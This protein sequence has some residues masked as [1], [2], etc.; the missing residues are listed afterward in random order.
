MENLTT[1]DRGQSKAFSVNGGEHRIVD[2][3]VKHRLINT[4]DSNIQYTQS[5]EYVNKDR[6]L[7]IQSGKHTRYL[8]VSDLSTLRSRMCSKG[9]L[10]VPQFSMFSGGGIKADGTP[11]H[12]VE[13]PKVVNLFDIINVMYSDKLIEHTKNIQHYRKLGDHVTKN[14]LKAELPYF[15][16]AGIFSRRENKC[17]VQPS[18][19]FQLDIDHVPNPW[20][21]LDKIVKDRRLKVLL[22]TTSTS[23]DGVKALLF[24]PELMTI[25]VQ[26]THE[27]YRDAYHQATEIMA[28]YFDRYY[29]LSID[30]SVKSISQPFYLF[31][32]SILYSK[33]HYKA[34]SSKSNYVE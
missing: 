13:N 21:V 25:D 17:L 14:R 33:H 30:T 11:W 12:C 34:W 9:Y 28:D 19:T 26:W 10:Y 31:G 15:T 4:N 32:T 22:A 20:R 23:G 24:L 8:F 7:F 6:Y 5:A 18:F 27:L 2:Q 3:E 1:V 29:N 16:P